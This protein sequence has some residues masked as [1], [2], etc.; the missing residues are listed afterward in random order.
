MN[1]AGGLRMLTQRDDASPP[2]PELSGHDEIQCKMPG[3]WYYPLM[4]ETDEMEEMA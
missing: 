1:S 3:V 4:E 2:H